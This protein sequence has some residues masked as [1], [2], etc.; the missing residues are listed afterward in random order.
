VDCPWP[1]HIVVIDQDVATMTMKFE[2]PIIYTNNGIPPKCRQPQTYTVLD[3]A[4]FE[5][6]VADI[7]ELEPALTFRVRYNTENEELRTSE[8]VFKQYRGHLMRA[9]DASRRLRG[10]RMLDAGIL[11]TLANQDVSWLPEVLQVKSSRFRYTYGTA[12]EAKTL[13]EKH[14]G[15]SGRTGAIDE[16]QAFINDNLVIVDGHVFGKIHDPKINVNVSHNGYS[17]D[18]SLIASGTFSFP[19][20]R[21]DLVDDFTSWLEVEFGLQRRANDSFVLDKEFIVDAAEVPLSANP[22][23]EASLELS[24]K[25]QL[26]IIN[27]DYY[28]PETKQLGLAF[29]EDPTL[30]NAFAFADA[31]EVAAKLPGAHKVGYGMDNVDLLF[32][33]FRKFVE[34]MPDEYKTGFSDTIDIPLSFD[35]VYSARRP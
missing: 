1:V 11:S 9:V 13:K 20:D 4:W 28:G 16:L 25:A 7:S 34:L 12:H 15:T 6:P 22:V 19:F 3:N 2:L 26:N 27:A 21:M 29:T 23:I 32:S 8:T 30:E 18:P 10:E 5:F 17:V 14:V 35:P 31:F 24:N 33:S